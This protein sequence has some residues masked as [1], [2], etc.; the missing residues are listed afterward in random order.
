MTVQNADFVNNEPRGS[1]V[2]GKSEI[3]VFG[4]TGNFTYSVD[5]SSVVFGGHQTSGKKG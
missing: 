3:I 1:H 2:L 4:G 5:V